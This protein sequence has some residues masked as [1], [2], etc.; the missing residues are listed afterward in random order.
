LLQLP[1]AAIWVFD[2]I[3]Q[4]QTYM[5]SNDFSSS[6]LPGMAEGNP[7]WIAPL[8]PV[9]AHIVEGSPVLISSAF[10]T[11]QLGIGLAIAFRPTHA[12]G[13]GRLGRVVAGGVVVR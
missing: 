4:Y 10:A 7:S 8:D 9:G 5:F 1:L 2:G 13:A 6:F 12:G 11:L 3:L